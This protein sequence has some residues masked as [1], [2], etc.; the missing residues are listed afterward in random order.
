M[1][2]REFRLQFAIRMPNGHLYSEPTKTKQ[3]Y[4]IYGTPMSAMFAEWFGGLG[5]DIT[6]EDTPPPDGVR[7]RIFDNEDDAIKLLVELQER[8][9]AVGVPY[10][11]G[12][13][14][15]SLCTPFTTA[16]PAHEFVTAIQA[17]V[18]KETQ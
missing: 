1:N 10:W 3:D 11:G 12:A 6:Q 14:V 15:K 8:A 18:Q 5:I 13:V 16:D 7:A 4:G 17:F 9:A 2:G